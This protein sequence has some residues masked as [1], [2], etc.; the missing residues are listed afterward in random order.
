MVERVPTSSNANPF[1]RAYLR[2]KKMRL[3][4]LMEDEAD[5]TVEADAELEEAPPLAD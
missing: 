5:G 3:G 2:T 1:N 4:H